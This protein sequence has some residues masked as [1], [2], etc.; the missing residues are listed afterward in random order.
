[1]RLDYDGRLRLRRV[2][3]VLGPAVLVPV[4]VWFYVVTPPSALAA[5]SALVGPPSVPSSAL[6]SVPSP[7]LSPGPSSVPSA[8]PSSVPSPGP[9]SVPSSAPS[10]SAPSVAPSVQGNAVPQ[11]P[12]AAVEPGVLVRAVAAPDGS[13]D[14]V[15]T[16][17]LAEPTARL[18]LVP[19]DLALAGPRFAEARAVP[20]GIEVV[21]P[22]QEPVPVPELG[23]G[24]TV[25]LAQ[26]TTSLEVRY[27]LDGVTVR[28]L[29]GPP[30]RALGAVAPLTDGPD[31]PTGFE[32]TGDPVRAVTCPTV[33]ANEAVCGRDEDGTLVVDAQ[34]LA[35][36]L[37]VAQLDLG[38]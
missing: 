30:G 37:V 35:T 32:L 22:D 24:R 26:A 7:V 4:A 8:T 29:P 25:P 17:R 14:V 10:S 28:T 18:R 9:S 12:P 2:A 15:E 36:A 27:H 19:R 33:P 21:L 20:S 3:G 34:P 38:T 13:F 31:L 11:D 23:T 6:S 1:V 16:V 5:P